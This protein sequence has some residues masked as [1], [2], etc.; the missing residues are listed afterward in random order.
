MHC[1]GP[2]TSRLRRRSADGEVME[3][4][5][6]S[7][8]CHTLRVVRPKQLGLLGLDIVSVLVFA[9]IGRAA[10]AKGMT[11]AGLASTSW[12]FLVGLVGGWLIGR[13]WVEPTALAPAGVAT[14]LVCVAAGMTLR[15]VSGQGTAFAF[16]LVALGF[17]GVTLL[18]WRFVS[19]C[20][21]TLRS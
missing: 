12:P 17:L 5:A 4:A 11:P 16:I 21:T 2:P 9:A 20:V 1:I 15:V 8:R 18:G 6:G 14:W 13:A 10:H 3:P 7:P 19:R